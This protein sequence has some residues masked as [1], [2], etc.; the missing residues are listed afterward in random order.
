MSELRELRPL[1]D[2]NQKLTQRIADLSLDKHMPQEVIAREFDA[3]GER[4]LVGWMLTA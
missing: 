4:Q 1:R 3:A 2:E